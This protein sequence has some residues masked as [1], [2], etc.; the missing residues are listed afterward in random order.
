MVCS[1]NAT[2]SGAEQQRDD[3]EHHQIEQ[4]GD[5]REPGQHHVRREHAPTTSITEKPRV[6][7]TW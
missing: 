7:A 5:D 2:S 1:S 6:V 4:H 3:V